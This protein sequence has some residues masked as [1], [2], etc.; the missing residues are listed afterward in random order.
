MTNGVPTCPI[1]V[2]RRPSNSSH[3]GMIRI[4]DGTQLIVLGTPL[5]AGLGILPGLQAVS[6]TATMGDD[7]GRRQDPATVA[8]TVI[9]TTM[10]AT[11]P[12]RP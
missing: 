8:C 12:S 4:E 11:A 3:P 1:L 2:S 9:A 6:A 10:L 5:D 7:R